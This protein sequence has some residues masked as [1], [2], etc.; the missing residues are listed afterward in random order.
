M[1]IMVLYL[2]YSRWDERILNENGYIFKWDERILNEN[3]DF[4][5][6]VNG[7]VCFWCIERQGIKEF[8]LIGGRYVE[9]F[10]EQADNLIFTF[11]RGDGNRHTYM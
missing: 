3:G 10:I 1:L 6:V 4:A 8:K 2:L 11:V 7:T 5:F 9:S